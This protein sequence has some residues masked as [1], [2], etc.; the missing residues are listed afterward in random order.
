MPRLEQ[1]T[2][3]GDKMLVSA[4]MACVGVVSEMVGFQP[5]AV[6]DFTVLT[7]MG[8]SFNHCG[9]RTQKSRG[10]RSQGRLSDGPTII[11]GTK[12]EL[13]WAWLGGTIGRSNSLQ[14]PLRQHQSW[15]GCKLHQESGVV[16]LVWEILGK[17]N[18]RQ[19]GA[20]WTSHW[21]VSQMIVAHKLQIHFWVLEGSL[22]EG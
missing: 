14:C 2:M 9:A 16:N 22:L 13:V 20:V 5:A 19:T 21:H 6:D 8:S 1:H 10:E 11:Q 17:L 15:T 3:K 12:V 7:S 18:T 4:S